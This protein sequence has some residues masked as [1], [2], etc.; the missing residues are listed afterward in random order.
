M[1]SR[2]IER[3]KESK[4]DFQPYNKNIHQSLFILHVAILN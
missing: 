3:K 1:K 2:N 4:L